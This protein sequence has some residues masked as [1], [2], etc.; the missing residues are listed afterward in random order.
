M[1]V[2][3]CVCVCVCTC[4][5][6]C[7]YSERVEAYR[8]IETHKHKQTEGQISEERQSDTGITGIQSVCV[9]L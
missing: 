2:C 4:V 3:V 1:C 8:Q 6:T 5:P 7:V 9:C